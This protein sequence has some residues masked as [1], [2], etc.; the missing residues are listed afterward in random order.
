MLVLTPGDAVVLDN[1]SSHKV[2]GVRAA[3]EAA[4]ARL[5][6]M[7]PYSPDLN[8]IELAFSKLKPPAPR[9]GGSGAR[10]ANF[11]E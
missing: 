2:T 8:L 5:L 1:L 6:C 11:V 7:L 3:I 9:V 4:D 10:Q